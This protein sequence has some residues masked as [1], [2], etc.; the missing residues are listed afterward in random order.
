VAGRL[1]SCCADPDNT[2]IDSSTRERRDAGIVRDLSM[3]RRLQ[4]MIALPKRPTSNLVLVPIPKEPEVFF[5]IPAGARPS[6]PG[7]L[8]DAREYTMPPRL[9]WRAQA[10]PGQ[11]PADPSR[12]P[13]K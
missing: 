7:V 9:R 13:G 3:E 2:G 12:R 11:R 10:E 4:A 1:A 6:D 8:R 5:V